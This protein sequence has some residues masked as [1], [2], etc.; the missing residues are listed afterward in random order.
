M[1]SNLGHQVLNR[2]MDV[3]G[4]DAGIIDRQVGFYFEEVHS[5]PPG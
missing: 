1:I 3:K 4:S 2:S 5:C